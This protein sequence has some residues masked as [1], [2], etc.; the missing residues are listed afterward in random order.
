MFH[1]ATQ[2][3][4]MDVVTKFLR[5]IMLAYS[6][7]DYAPVEELIHTD[8]SLRTK[9]GVKT[10]IDPIIRHLKAEGK[11]RYKATIVAPKGGLTTVIISPVLADGV[12]G[13]EHEIVLRVHRDKIAE[14]I[15]LQRTPDM[16]YRPE[17]QPF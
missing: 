10:G 3:R 11:Q 5:R 16:V 8:A 9:E 2:T 7:W 1:R 17:S 13:K 15:D 6:T 14:V 12:R 4:E